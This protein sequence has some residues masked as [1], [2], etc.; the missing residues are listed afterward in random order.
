MKA[1]D[2]TVS[3]VLGRDSLAETEK[4][5]GKRHEEFTEDERMGAFFKFI[6]DNEMKAEVL[7]SANDTYRGMSW[8]EFISLLETNG[9]KLQSNWQYTAFDE[10]EDAVIYEKD[11]F[12][13]FAT[14]YRGNIDSG[15]IYAEIEIRDGKRLDDI[16]HLSGGYFDSSRSHAAVYYDIREGLMNFIKQVNETGIVLPIWETKK[17]HPWVITFEETQKNDGKYDE[18]DKIR[19]QRISESSERIKS[20]CSPFI[21][22]AFVLKS[23]T[24][25]N[26]DLKYVNLTSNISKIESGAFVNCPNLEEIIIKSDVRIPIDMISNCPNLKRLVVHG[27]EIPLANGHVEDNSLTGIID[28]FKKQNEDVE[29]MVEQIQEKK[30][31]LI[32][33][34]EK[35]KK[36]NKDNIINQILDIK[37]KIQE[38]KYE[39]IKLSSP[40]FSMEEWFGRLEITMESGFFKGKTVDKSDKQILKMLDELIEDIEK[41]K[42]NT[43]KIGRKAVSVI[44]E[45]ATLLQE[46][47]DKINGKLKELGININKTQKE[48]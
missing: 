3:S 38:G 45:Q 23:N 24:Y 10:K 35:C 8:E 39:N 31:Q 29:K 42:I 48:R 34:L 21:N 22:E 6:L 11:G 41:D 7:K 25:S 5:L 17:P 33:L 44:N 46:S 28:G 18:Y 32:T 26:L 30:A 36:Q 40:K 14:S 1:D 13:L 12:L 15:N 47:I 2:K 37:S 19:V 27:V 16:D 4:M 9:F 43:V 20:L